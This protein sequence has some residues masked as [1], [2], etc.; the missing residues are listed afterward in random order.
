MSMVAAEDRKKAL[1][2]RLAR[3]EGQLRGL[4]RLIEADAERE[5]LAQQMAAARK[6]LDKAFFAMVADL[7]ADGR[8]SADDIAELLLRFA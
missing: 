5:K 6:A 7:I 4:Q 2:A 1:C 8:A 3:V